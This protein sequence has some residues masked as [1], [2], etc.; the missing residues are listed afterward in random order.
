MKSSS[1]WILVVLATAL[2]AFIFLFDR[3]PR[4]PD[5][6][7]RTL[8]HGLKSENVNQLQIQWSNQFPLKVIRTNGGWQI[9]NPLVYPAQALV[10]DRLLGTLEKLES[11]THIA[12]RELQNNSKADEEFGFGNPL[13]T[14][15]LKEGADTRQLKVGKFTAPGD[16]L[17]V[18]VVG[19]EG[20]DTVD[21]ALFGVVP[22]TVNDLRDTALVKLMGV[23][24]NRITIAAGPKTESSRMEL[25]RDGKSDPWRMQFPLQA[26]VDN[27]R[28]DELVFGLETLQA[29]GFE[30]D[31]PGTDLDQFGLQPPQ[32]QV[33][34]GQGTNDLAVL[35][36]GKGSTNDNN[37]I[38]A[39]RAGQKTIM[40]V[41]RA[42]VEAWRGEY[43][44]FRDRRLAGPHA[45]DFD[46]IEMRSNAGEKFT[47][48]R[49]TNGVW[50][51]LEAP[52]FTLDLRRMNEF[53]DSLI[54]LEVVRINGQFAVKENVDA[55]A[56]GTNY[57]LAQP[58]RQYL[59]KKS[60]ASLPPG[61]TNDVLV[62]LDFGRV[63]PEDKDKMYARR[64][65]ESAVYAV[66]RSQFLRLPSSLMQLRE[67]R[68]WK[69]VAEDLKLL[70]L[71]ENGQSMAV[72][73][74]GPLDYVIQQG[75]GIID[76]AAME[77][78]AVDLGE[79]SVENWVAKGATNRA[80]FGFSDKSPQ[81]VADLLIKGQRQT[82]T[83]DLGGWSTNRLRFGAVTM[84]GQ[85]WIFELPHRLYESLITSLGMKQPTAP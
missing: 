47:L 80:E 61:T 66:Q 26:R 35:Q 6:P 74:R 77:S 70:T 42:A 83:L 56:L 25:V 15:T 76:S 51:A 62:E 54:H 43:T 52:D 78:A 2:F 53:V 44:D 4:K 14:F 49:Q 21:K 72:F 8:L 60:T 40:L 30:T 23:N 69:F 7:T 41:P 32:L 36:F 46:V 16:E 27:S 67:H 29:V 24:F 79:L 12:A 81:I 10:V 13:V 50:K 58:L 17:Y 68:V 48:Q 37:Q 28:V 64:P 39:R 71:R 63:I 57:G 82:L 3:Q 55:S 19:G 5:V 1:T 18:Q 85:E 22:R 9:I 31:D 59:L 65:D 34:L 75:Q 20:I 84:E 73:H 33:T 11:H 45:A 38:Y